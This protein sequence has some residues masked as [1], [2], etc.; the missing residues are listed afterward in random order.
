[1]RTE[2]LELSKQKKTTLILCVLFPVAINIMLC[3]SLKYRYESYLLPRIDVYGISRWQL[4]FKEQTI[5]YFSE[6]CH[7]IAGALVFE[8]FNSEMKNNSWMLIATSE[9]RRKVVISK[10][11]AVAFDLLVIFISD[12]VTLT[13][14][15]I[16]T[17]V[18]DP[19]DAGL[20]FK[21]FFIQL[22]SACMYAAFYIFLVAF[23]K[24]LS[25]VLPSSIAFMLLD[26]TMYYGKG[27]NYR[28]NYFIPS[29]Y[30]S[31]NSLSTWTEASVITGFSAVSVLVLLFISGRMLR[32]NCDIRS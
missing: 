8:S 5:L 19:W 3:I 23:T 32:K 7:I 6:I 28:F 26:I 27:F 12:Y 22:S 13:A 21:G 29:L 10:F 17:G 4:I 9:Y 2:T 14:A 30:V 20:F 31:H 1:M 18:K 16:I 11:T 25:W 24:K 15:G